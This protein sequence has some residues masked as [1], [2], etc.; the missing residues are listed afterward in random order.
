MFRVENL[1]KYKK[2][3]HNT[4]KCI[5]IPQFNNI[6]EYLLFKTQR[7][8]FADSIVWNYLKHRQHSHVWALRDYVEKN[9]SIK[10]DLTSRSIKTA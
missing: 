2:V 4:H 3:S 6:P 8:D 10:K 5:K 1:I 9:N 7:R